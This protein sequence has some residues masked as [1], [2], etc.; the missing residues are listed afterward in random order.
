M[1][2]SG[3]EPAGLLSRVRRR[4]KERPWTSGRVLMFLVVCFATLA[5]ALTYTVLH[6]NQRCLTRQRTTVAVSGR[7]P[8]RRHWQRSNLAAE[9]RF[10]Q[11]CR[12]AF[13]G[14]VGRQP[15]QLESVAIVGASGRM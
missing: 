11:Q 2:Q 6:H 8:K 5:S 9:L 10:R 13:G 12:S 4:S 7:G 15:K 14:S 3:A 1:I